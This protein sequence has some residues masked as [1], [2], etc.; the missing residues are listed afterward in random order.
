MHLSECTYMFG[1]DDLNV[2]VSGAS[3][4]TYFSYY[5]LGASAECVL[6]KSYS[7]FRTLVGGCTYEIIILPP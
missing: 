6:Q 5:S 4:T 2:Y 7:Y 3:L 1:Q